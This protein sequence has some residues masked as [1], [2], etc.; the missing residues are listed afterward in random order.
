MNQLFMNLDFR[1]FIYGVDVTDPEGSQTLLH[2]L[3]YLFARLQLGNDKA[4]VPQELAHSIIDFEGHPINIHIQMDVDEFF[5]L[6]FD[7]IEGQF[8]HMLEKSRFRR[9]YGGVLCHTIKSRECSHVSTREEDFAAIQCDVRGK[10]TL[11]DSLSSYVQGEMMDGGMTVINHANLDNKYSCE[12]CGRH[13]DAVKQISIKSLPDNLIFHLKRFEYAVDLNK[14]IKV[15]DYFS[16]PDT[17]DLYPYTLGHIEMQEMGIKRPAQETQEIYELVGVLVHTGTA[18]SGHYYSYIRDPRSTSAGS[19]AQWFEFND[20]DVKP[21]RVEELEHWCYGGTEQSYDP[22]Y[23]QEA[24]M[25]SYSAY[26]LF[27]RRRPKVA[28]QQRLPDP[29]L[30]PQRLEYAV[31]RY[32]DEFVRKYVIFADDLCGF[33]TKL[34][35]SMPQSDSSPLEHCEINSLEDHIEGI[36]PLK[37]GLEVY[38]LIVTRMDSRSSVEKYCNALKS[39]VR[40]SPA[41]RHYFYAWLLKT[42][43]CLR[44]LLLTNINEKARMQAG[45]LISAALTS[46]EVAKPRTWRN[47]GID[48]LDIDVVSSVIKDLA[49]LV[50]TAGDVWR[51]WSE[52]FETLALIAKD[53]D[54]AKLLIEQNMM[55]N[56]LYHFL[57]AHYH[58][59]TPPRGFA[60][61]KYPDNDRVRPNYKKLILLLSRLVSYVYI[62]ESNPHDERGFT[63]NPEDLG[64][65]TDEEWDC[66]FFDWD[67]DIPVMSRSRTPINVFIHRLFETSCDVMD[68][69]VIIIWLLTETITRDNL[70][71]PK[72]AIVNTIFRQADPGGINTAEALEVVWHLMEHTPELE[73]DRDRWHSLMLY[74]TKRIGVWSE[75]LRETY[76]GQEYFAF[77]KRLFDQPEDDYKALVIR[78]LPEIVSCLLFSNESSVRERVAVWI[79]MI[80][81]KYSQ[82]EMTEDI[83][84]VECMSLLFNKLVWQT[85]LF[86]E[87]K[88]IVA[89]RSA[90]MFQ[91]VTPAL[92]VLRLL[93]FSFNIGKDNPE[94]I[95]ERMVFRSVTNERYPRTSQNGAIFARY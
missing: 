43:G 55:A 75:H 44:E 6:L 93:V 29:V 17:I 34:L 56:I 20:S 3:Q 68:I 69:S 4:A 46:D 5:N 89:E 14:R 23:Y 80:I 18:E 91:V 11:E 24:P 15:N 50:Y 35:R 2:Q 19:K 22:Q 90:T 74:M 21:W 59:S 16:F 47:N 64:W 10:H 27:Y 73:E 95:I 40:S 9:L 57:H 78:Y 36:W 13:V 87:R 53:P 25:K 49:N 33:I 60:R 51:Y 94:H 28:I 86:L 72:V 82:E 92:E 1:K 61:L 12:A 58:R 32:N 83:V 88:F 76:Y 38:R 65:I 26:M 48:Q 39:A 45:L 62:P 77:W 42:P 79:Q 84:V 7:R 67:T 8:K 30:P 37:L 31:Q 70:N 41:A 63:N 66:F 85:D 71:R 52:Y 81:A 54:W